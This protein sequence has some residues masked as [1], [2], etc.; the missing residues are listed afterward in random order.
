MTRTLSTR[1][2]PWTDIR[3][4]RAIRVVDAWATTISISDGVRKEKWGM[5]DRKRSVSGFIDASWAWR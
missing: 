1:L 5:D 4:P 3:S 2:S